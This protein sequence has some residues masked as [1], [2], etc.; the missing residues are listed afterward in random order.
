VTLVEMVKLLRDRGLTH[1]ESD[2][3]SSR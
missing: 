3:N 2:F 1:V